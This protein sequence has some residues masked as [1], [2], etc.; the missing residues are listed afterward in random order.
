MP[1]WREARAA[2][3]RRPR[4]RGRGRPAGAGGHRRA[5]AGRGHHHLHLRHRRGLRRRAA[6]APGHRGRRALLLH[7]DSRGRFPTCF[8]SE[9]G[10]TLEVVARDAVFEMACGAGVEL[11]SAERPAGRDWRRAA[12]ASGWAIWWP[13]RRSRSSSRVGVRSR[14][15]LGGHGGARA[16]WRPRPRA[17]S[18]SRCA[19]DW[20][21][22][23]AADNDAQ[24][25]NQA[26]VLAVATLLAERA[27]GRALAANRRGAFDEAQ[28]ILAEAVRELRPLAAGNAVVE[29]LVAQLQHEQADFAE[30]MSPANRKQRH[31]RAYPSRPARAI[32]RARRTERPRRRDWPDRRRI[33]VGRRE[34][35]NQ[36]LRPLTWRGGAA[37]PNCRLFAAFTNFRWHGTPDAIDTVGVAPLRLVGDWLPPG[38]SLTMQAETH[39]PQLTRITRDARVMGGKPCIRGM[40]IT[41]GTVV[42]LVAAGHSTDQILRE[43]PVLGD[44]RHRRRRCPTPLGARRK[45]KCPWDGREAGARPESVAE[46]RCDAYA[47]WLRSC[48]LVSDWLR[49]GRRLGDSVVGARA[50]LRRRDPRP[51]LLGDPGG[52]RRRV[53]ECRASPDARRA[54]RRSNG[55]PGSGAHDPRRRHRAR[56]A[57]V[58]ERVGNTRQNLATATGLTASALAV[59][60]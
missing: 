21:V 44:R 40:R 6:R 4:Q 43:Y 38:R 56:G 58:R 34:G 8:A 48:P 37:N 60:H 20:P 7:R 16:A 23:T 14:R 51:R 12:C 36:E 13:T 5:A 28:R 45:W 25:V 17:L 47:R 59:R 29:A 11:G 55:A 9:L 46:R 26:V 10:E 24:P 27:R 22:V 35:G 2:A 15:P 50:R 52:R 32:S 33:C 41:V 53:P 54:I 19:V 30:A 18:R 31:F 3:H 39:M 49:D 42:G 1:A 57:A